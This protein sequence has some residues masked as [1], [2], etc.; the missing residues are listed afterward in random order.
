M[1]LLIDDDRHRSL[2]AQDTRLKSYNKKLK[3]AH[4]NQTKAENRLRTAIYANDTAVIA[5]AQ[6]A[7]DKAAVAYS[8]AL[9]SSVDAIGSGSGKVAILLPPEQVVASRS[10]QDRY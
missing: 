9:A 2:D 6:K 10:I 7:R 4:T 1:H 8:K 5:K 3:A